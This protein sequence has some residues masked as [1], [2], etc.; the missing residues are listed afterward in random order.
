MIE[1]AIVDAYDE[2]EQQTGF[3]TMLD[4]H[5]ALPFT[6]VLLGVAVEVR[7]IEA[8]AAGEI[9]AMCHRGKDKLCVPILNLPLPI[10]PPKG[11]EWIE[12]YRHWRRH[13]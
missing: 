4:E 6:T 2:D 5:L 9:V 7:K 13:G 1:E 3:E 12:A 8:S 10:P 11:A